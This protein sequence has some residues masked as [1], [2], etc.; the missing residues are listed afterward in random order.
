MPNQILVIAP[1]WSDGSWVFDDE[2]RGLRREPFVSGADT[3][4]T[5]LSRD[6]PDAD[7]GFQLLFSAAPFPGFQAKVVWVRSEMSGDWYRGGDPP[8]EGWLCPALLRYFEEPPK[9]L[10][11]KCSPLD[12]V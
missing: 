8:M 2:A 6:I 5:R 7:R 3:F 10:Y 11:F 12:V 4:L 1:Y 9:E